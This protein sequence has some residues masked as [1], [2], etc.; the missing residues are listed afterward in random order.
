MHFDSTTIEGITGAGD[1][2]SGFFYPLETD[3][4]PYEFEHDGESNF[5]VWLDCSGGNNLFQNEIGAVSNAAVVKFSGDICLWEVKAD[6]NW[7]FTTL[8]FMCAFQ[9]P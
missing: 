6:G 3:H 7:T 5:T 4:T 2:V 9:F 1:Y 8:I